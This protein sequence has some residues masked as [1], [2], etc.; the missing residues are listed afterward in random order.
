MSYAQ[1][2][3]I[4]K[5]IEHNLGY[6]LLVKKIGGHAGGGSKLTAEGEKLLK[7]YREFRTKASSSILQIY[8]ETFNAADFPDFFD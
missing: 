2:W 6:A 4:I 1:A 3:E 8:E 7:A 5:M